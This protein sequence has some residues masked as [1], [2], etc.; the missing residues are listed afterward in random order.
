MYDITSNVS[1]WIGGSN[2]ASPAALYPTLRGDGALVVQGLGV[3]SGAVWVSPSGSV[4]YG[5]G[6]SV[7]GGDCNG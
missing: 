4:Y 6:L 3:G 2:V 5:F 1:T 7:L